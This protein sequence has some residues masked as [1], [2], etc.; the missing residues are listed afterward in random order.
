MTLV[1]ILIL[2]AIVL[3][4]FPLEAEERAQMV[5]RVQ[6]RIEWIWQTCERDPQFCTNAVTAWQGFL[7]HAEDALVVSFEFVRMA[8]FTDPK[9][10]ADG[11]EQPTGTLTRA[12]LEPAWAAP[13]PAPA[14]SQP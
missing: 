3:V 13:G 8:L 6:V 12:D 1:R 7:T 5:E 10:A 11:A 2:T 14:E 4:A 9:Q